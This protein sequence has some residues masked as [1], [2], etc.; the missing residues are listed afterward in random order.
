[1]N[2]K[3]RPIHKEAIQFGRNTF[4]EHRMI[5]V[6]MFLLIFLSYLVTSY[7][8]VNLLWNNTIQIITI[9]VDSV[10]SLWV[11]AIVLHIYNKK[12]PKIV[13]LFSQANK[14]L[15][16]IWSLLLYYVGIAIWLIALII[17][18]IVFALRCSFFGYFIV[19]KNLWPI[20][21]LKASRTHTKGHW[22]RLLGFYII[23]GCINILW[24]VALFVGL[25]VSL[26]VTSLASAYYYKKI[27]QNKKPSQ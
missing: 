21:A 25:L 20:D 19:E 2:K 12:T 6:W 22:R 4:K 8:D 17:P 7:I 11:I 18:W 24:F 9:V 27:T 3:N 13:M 14:I 16:Y 23:L 26:P 1:M 5:L 10:L 15:I